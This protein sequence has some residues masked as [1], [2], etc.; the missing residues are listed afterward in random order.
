MTGFQAWWKFNPKVQ[1]RKRSKDHI[2]R[3]EQWETLE[4]WLKLPKTAG[5]ESVKAVETEAKR[6]RSILHRLL[7]ITL[8][9]PK[10]NLAFC[11]RREDESSQNKWNFLV[12]AQMLS[13]YDPVLKEHAMRLKQRAEIMK[14]SAS[15]LPP[16]SRQQ[17][18]MSSLEHCKACTAEFSRGDQIDTILWDYIWQH[19]WHVLLW[20]NG[21]GDQQK[22]WSQGFLPLKGKKAAD[23]AG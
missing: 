17:L 18:R 11:G 1:E 12:L 4:T 13:K 6:P 7:D 2:C 10:Q 23:L 9:L 22:C 19:A 14:V 16:T 3:L 5:A 21:S 15:Y 8:F 20:S